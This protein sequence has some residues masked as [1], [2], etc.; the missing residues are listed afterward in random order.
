MRWIHSGPETRSGPDYPIS[1]PL[2]QCERHP[3]SRASHRAGAGEAWF[4]HRS[5]EIAATFAARRKLELPMVLPMRI[6]QL[7]RVALGSNSS[8]VRDKIS[9]RG[10][11]WLEFYF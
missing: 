2:Q 5:S 9:P 4:A 11:V 10:S 3:L 1:K 6:L 8:I 7:C